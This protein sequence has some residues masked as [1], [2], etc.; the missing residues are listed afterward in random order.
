MLLVQYLLVVGDLF[1]NLFVLLLDTGVLEKHVFFFLHQ[2]VVFRVKHRQLILE[3]L[4]APLKNIGIIRVEVV[5]VFAL[6]VLEILLGFMLRIVVHF[7]LLHAAN[8]LNRFNN[9]LLL[10]AVIQVVFQST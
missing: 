4:K 7:F 6:I 3:L 5:Q 8:I 2:L 1:K 10:T 9:M